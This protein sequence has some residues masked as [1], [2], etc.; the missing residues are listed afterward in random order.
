MTTIRHQPW[1][2]ILVAQQRTKFHPFKNISFRFDPFHLRALILRKY[3]SLQHYQ[4]YWCG[5]RNLQRLTFFTATLR[6]FFVTLGAL[7]SQKWIVWDW[8]ISPCVAFHLS[9]SFRAQTFHYIYIGLLNFVQKNGKKSYT[10]SG[11]TVSNTQIIP[12]AQSARKSHGIAHMIL[13]FMKH[14]LVDSLVQ[15]AIKSIT[16]GCDFC[17]FDLEN[18]WTTQETASVY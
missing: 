13:V 9:F 11:H 4:G 16:R 17:C 8:V 10:W 2:D 5:D 12:N 6:F 7:V 14:E 3:G 18:K 1:C 15:M